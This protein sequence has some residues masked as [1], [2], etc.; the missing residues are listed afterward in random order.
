MADT[1]YQPGDGIHEILRKIL[2]RLNEGLQTEGESSGGDV[3]SRTYA[4]VK[5]FSVTPSTTQYSP[6]DVFGGLIEIQN[7]FLT[8]A[9]G[10]DYATAELRSISVY[11]NQGQA[12]PE[13]ELFFFRGQPSGTFTD[14]QP[15]TL[16]SS[17][18]ELCYARA[19][20]LAADYLQINNNYD[21]FAQI[22]DY[23]LIVRSASNTNLSMYVVPVVLNA[24]VFNS[25]KIVS[26]R[27]GL[28][29][30]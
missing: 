6:F 4:L 30:H 8:P 18:S 5:E 29:Q 7:A 13:L 28:I 17:D 23:R 24:P 10:R 3:G 15:F 27:L 25:G 20:I 1:Q 9:E 21:T 22:F 14:N 16:L 12:S 2:E 19:S 11:C 26:V